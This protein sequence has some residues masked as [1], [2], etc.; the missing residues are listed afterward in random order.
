MRLLV[1]L[2]TDAQKPNEDNTTPLLVAAGVG[3]NSPG[4]DPGTEPE[5]LLAVQFALELGADLNHVDDNGESV[6][7]GAAYKH[8]PAV[9]RY[10]ADR[11]ADIEIWNRENAEG[12]TPLRITEGVHRGMNI[13]SSRITEAAIREVMQQAGI[14]AP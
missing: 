11:G 9:V 7:H 1:E 8:L 12:W 5:V 4:E 14:T 3:T 10:L 6:M 13:V 2:G